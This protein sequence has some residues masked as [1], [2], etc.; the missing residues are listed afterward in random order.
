MPYVLVGTSILPIDRTIKIILKWAVMIRKNL[1]KEK[2]S[3][4]WKQ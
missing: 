2:F 4:Y 3:K 1:N